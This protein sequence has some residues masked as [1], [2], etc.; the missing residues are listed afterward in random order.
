MLLAHAFSAIVSAKTA[1]SQLGQMQLKN[2]G[3]VRPG[4]EYWLGRIRPKGRSLPTP[5]IEDYNTLETGYTI[6]NDETRK[7][8]TRSL[9]N[10][11][12]TPDDDDY[13]TNK[14]NA[15]VNILK[16]QPPDVNRIMY[17]YN[18]R[19]TEKIYNEIKQKYNLTDSEIFIN[20]IDVDYVIPEP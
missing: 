2:Q 19:E 9:R 16:R 17:P 1:A 8:W 7:P 15:N 3:A 18:T 14:Y 10:G 5:A 20:Y 13:T 4:L 11:I 12:S 6:R